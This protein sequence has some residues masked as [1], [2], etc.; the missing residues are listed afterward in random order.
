MNIDIDKIDILLEQADRWLTDGAT[1]TSVPIRMKWTGGPDSF[2]IEYDRDRAGLLIIA[3][4]SDPLLAAA[5]SAALVKVLSEYGDLRRRAVIQA[6]EA[7][8][9]S[10]HARMAEEGLCDMEYPLVFARNGR[11]S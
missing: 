3:I 8:L 5:A 1:E 6:F 2:D 7:A 4:A 11:S 9:E 10:V